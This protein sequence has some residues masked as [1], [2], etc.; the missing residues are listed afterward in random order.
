MLVGDKARF[1]IESYISQYTVFEKHEWL[2]GG[3]LFYCNNLTIGNPKD[4]FVVLPYCYG[5]LMDFLYY[6]IKHV[7]HDKL[8][9]LPRGK[10]WDVV[11]E[12]NENACPFNLP[13]DFYTNQC[14]NF[15]L[16]E[17]GYTS[18]DEFEI[19]FIKNSSGNERL[20]WKDYSSTEKV[21][22][23]FEL[24]PMEFEN[25]LLT[26]ETEFKNYCCSNPILAK[27]DVGRI[28]DWGAGKENC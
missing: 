16:N 13:N 6:R 9:K 10:L 8:F 17:I 1:A 11:C 27:V 2:Y 5:W 25:V 28:L 18:F 24:K 20:L 26:F 14:P 19:V 3:F 7:I 23:D 21:I 22:N 12:E 15:R 4:D